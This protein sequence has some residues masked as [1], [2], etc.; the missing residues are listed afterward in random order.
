[1]PLMNYFLLHDF[2]RQMCQDL[3][4]YYGV[5]GQAA[6]EDFLCTLGLRRDDGTLRQAWAQFQQ[7]A[8]EAGL[9]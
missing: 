3:G 6:F 7:Q 2:A 4:N 8:S 9:P 1:V 5:G